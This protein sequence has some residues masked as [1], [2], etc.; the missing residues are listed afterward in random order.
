MRNI[1]CWRLLFFI[2]GIMTLSIGIVFTMRAGSIG[3]GSW[4]VLHVGLAKTF[5]L[6]VGNWSII[7]GIAI[8]II[9]GVFSK[10]L[11]R[12]GTIIDMLLTGIFI[13]L[14]NI[15]IPEVTTNSIQIISYLLGILMLSFGIGMYIIA[16]LGVGPRDTLMMLIVNRSNW[17]VAKTRTVIEVSVAI[18]G[19]ALGGPVGIGT[20]IMAF[21]LGPLVQKAMKINE[22]LFFIATGIRQEQYN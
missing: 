3:V 7:I 1:Y 15:L 6:T 8:L 2:V 17:S 12:M 19:F 11:P 10:R 20:I 9:D 21:F 14:F 16:N 18:V 13:D 22:H 5:G 4:D